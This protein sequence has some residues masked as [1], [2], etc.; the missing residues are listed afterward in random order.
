[1]PSQA[2]AATVLLV[3]LGFT[4]C[5]ATINSGPGAAV[6][7]IQSLLIAG[8]SLQT[9]W[10]EWRVPADSDYALGVR[11]VAP[12]LVQLLLIPPSG[13]PVP[14]NPVPG[15][16]GRFAAA[17]VATPGG[18]YLLQG[19]V[20]GSPLSAET[21]V[22]DSLEIRIPAQDTVRIAPGACAFCRLAYHWDAAG[23][24]AFFYV[25]SATD[26]ATILHVGSTNDTIGVISVFSRGGPDT[27]ALTIYA[28][29]ANAASFMLPYTPNGSIVGV[30]GLF[31][32]ASRAQ[33]WIVWQ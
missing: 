15:V 29:D 5:D 2:S 26:T 7:V 28:L 9:A 3:S 25:H 8:E 31:G 30:F 23:A 14:Y 24:E 4:A 18:R 22:P 1:M 32:A 21:M 19:T 13:S 33:R 6:P 16:P 17:V 10:V 12:N 20:A 11:P 27:T